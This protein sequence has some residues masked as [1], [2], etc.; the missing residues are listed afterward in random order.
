MDT[1]GQSAG[2][3][4]DDAAGA[5]EPQDKTQ[6]HPRR[7]WIAVGLVLIVYC[8]LCAR[9]ISL[10]P[11]WG[12]VHDEP[13]HFGY[14]KYLALRGQLPSLWDHKRGSLAECYTRPTA[15]EA[16]HHPPG[17]YALGALVCLPLRKAPLP[18]QNYALRCMS[19][20]LGLASLIFVYLGLRILLPGGLRL[21]VLTVAALAV[22]PHWLLVSSVIYPE[23][24]CAFA[25]SGAFWALARYSRARG[26][27]A[28]LCTAGVFVGLM[29]LGKVTML[30]F[31]LGAGLTFIVLGKRSGLSARAQIGRVLCFAGVVL[32]VGGWWYARNVAIYGQLFPSA[33]LFD[34]TTR[35]TR[36]VLGDGSSDMVGLLFVP[37]GRLYYRLAFTGAFRYFWSPDDWLP[38]ATHSVMYGIGGLTWLA[39]LVGLVWGWR[40]RAEDLM[41]LAAPWVLPFIA[42]FILLFFVYLRWTVTVAIQGHAELG[43]WVTPVLGQIALICA[44]SMRA[45]LGRWAWV[46][47]A[48]VVAFL[49]AW[50]ILSIHHIGTVL[51]PLHAGGLEPPP[52]L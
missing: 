23:V 42:S 9:L 40:R 45:L 46:A 51:I 21:V 35:H 3:A 49:L 43:K 10:L 44:L 38:P 29:S 5:V 20:A 26:A 19:L 25:A 14:C 48:G 50:D 34:G 36:V 13:I 7:Q 24:F 32:A 12:A 27:W 16:A 33:V 52:G 17:Y 30:P 2:S 31:C 22:F 11:L 6:T 18:H 28:W 4:T 37:R 47:V 1:A 39:T 41:R 15:G 8:G